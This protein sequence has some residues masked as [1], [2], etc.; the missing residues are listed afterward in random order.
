MFIN[1]TCKEREGKTS[2]LALGGCLNELQV[3][4][5]MLGVKRFVLRC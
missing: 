3:M 4:C 1:T 2:T 5:D